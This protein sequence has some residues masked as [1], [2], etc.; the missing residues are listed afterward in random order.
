MVFESFSLDNDRSLQVTSFYRR[1]SALSTF[2]SLFGL[3][4]LGSQKQR[5]SRLKKALVYAE[6][7]HTLPGSD[8]P[9]FKRQK[10]SETFPFQ[11]SGKELLASAMPMDVDQIGAHTSETLSHLNPPSSLRGPLS[12]SMPKTV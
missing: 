11:N 7:I 5:S 10:T 4:E 1:W 3:T 6:R 8:E 12:S 9:Q 2:Y